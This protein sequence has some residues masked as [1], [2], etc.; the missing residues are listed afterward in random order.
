MSAEHS[1]LIP[2]SS[3][4]DAAARA[5]VAAKVR[6]AVEQARVAEQAALDA[7][8]QAREGTR[9]AA[10]EARIEAQA[11][12]REAQAAAR[13]AQ[14]AAQAGAPGL[15]IPP[16]PDRVEVRDGHVLVRDERGNIV[17]EISVPPMGPWGPGIPG[18]I[19]PRA[20]HVFSMFFVTLAVIAIG[21]PLARAFGRWLDRRGTRPPALPADVTARLQRI[22]EAVETVALEVERISEGQRFTSRLMSEMRQAPQLEGV[23]A[24]GARIPEPRR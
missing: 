11:A 6:Q 14:A 5:D 1:I 7:A 24:E 9:E 20:E 4:Q 23:H 12:A 2:Q 15:D 16:A 19:P 13:E 22:E 8:R 3:T 21:I 17:Q 18:D 10:R